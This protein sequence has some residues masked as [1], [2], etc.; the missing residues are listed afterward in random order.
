MFKKLV[1]LMIVLTFSTSV[2]IPSEETWIKTN[3][4]AEAITDAARDVNR[5][6]GLIVGY[7]R[8]IIGA[9]SVKTQHVPARIP[10]VPIG[11]LIGKSP[12]YVAAYSANYQANQA[13]QPQSRLV[14]T[15]V[16]LVLGIGCLWM[17]SNSIDDYI[18]ENSS[19][20]FNVSQA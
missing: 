16:C 18:E 4:I 10:I 11:R 13:A 15:V 3:I 20:C 19:G 1:A 6:S 12:E 5:T 17:I 9:N 8:N 14:G 2:A 7:Y